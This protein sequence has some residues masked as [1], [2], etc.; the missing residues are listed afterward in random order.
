MNT[1]NILIGLISQNPDKLHCL[2][3]YLVNV[4]VFIFV[5]N[6]ANYNVHNFILVIR[7]NIVYN[8]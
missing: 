6:N 5:E 7:L 1:F 2:S 4:I 8:V 3:S